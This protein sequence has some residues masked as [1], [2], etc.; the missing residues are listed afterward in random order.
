M[1]LKDITMLCMI[2]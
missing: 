1:D 2:F